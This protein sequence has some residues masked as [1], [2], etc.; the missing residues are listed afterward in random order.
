MRETLN[1]LE[2]IE[3][4]AETDARYKAGAY[5]FVLEALNYAVKKLK[6]P[7]HISGKELLEGIKQYAAG[8]FGPMALSVLE[9][10]GVS[11]TQDF[12]Q[13]VFSL[14]EAGIL[15]KTEQDSIEDFKDG[16]DFKKVFK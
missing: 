10:W 6:Q 9:H 1:L 11:S 13:I 15:T 7:R 2:A 12:G 3:L 5:N 16:Y 8:Q 4:I 14:V